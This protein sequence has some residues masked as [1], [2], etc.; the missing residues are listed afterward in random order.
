M[1][2]KKPLTVVGILV[3]Q[4]ADGNRIERSWDNI[5]EKEK[6]ELRVKLTD[7]AMAA[8]GYVRCST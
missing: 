2:K 5:P 6:K 4:D 8:A 1:A 3:T 7:N